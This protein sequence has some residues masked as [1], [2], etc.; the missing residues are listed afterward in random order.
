MSTHRQF[1]A[2]ISYRHVDPDRTW[3]QWLHRA[4]ESYRVPQGLVDKGY[5]KR[6]GVVFRDEDELA[7]SHDLSE[8]I[9]AALEASAHLLV[10]CSPRTPSSEWVNAEIARFKEMGRE[11]DVL[12][13]LIDGEPTESFPPALIP[14]LDDSDRTLP[15]S[16]E[17]EPLAAD[18]RPID[19]ESLRSRRRTALLRI[20]AS[21]LGCRYDDLRRREAQRRAKRRRIVAAAGL[22]LIGVLTGL[23][24]W[25]LREQARAEQSAQH[26][27]AQRERAEYLLG[28]TTTFVPEILRGIRQ[29][30]ARLRGSTRAQRRLSETIASYLDALALREGDDANLRTVSADTYQRLASIQ[31]G[32]EGNTLGN[33]Q[34]AIAQFRKAL[35]LYDQLAAELPEDRRRMVAAASARL[36]LAAV[37]RGVGDVVKARELIDVARASLER[38]HEEAPDDHDICVG[39]Y[40]ARRDAGA[41]A[42]YVGDYTTALKHFEDA[43]ELLKQDAAHIG[44][45]THGLELMLVAEANFGRALQLVGRADEAKPHFEET[46]RLSRL[47]EQR[48]DVDRLTLWRAH[49]QLGHSDLDAGEFPSAFLHFKRAL[50][51]AQAAVADDP[52][53]AAAG[54]SALSAHSSL[55]TTLEKLQRFKEA[56]PHVQ[57]ALDAARI[58]VKLDEQDLT[59]QW[60]LRVALTRVGSIQTRLHEFD[61]ARKNL[62]AARAIAKARVKAMPT[63]EERGG[64][65]EVYA[66]F[67]NLTMESLSNEVSL[68]E[69]IRVY[70][71]V[72]GWYERAASIYRAMD[73][74]GVLAQR[75]RPNLALHNTLV[76]TM[77][78]AIG[79]LEKLR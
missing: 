43:L 70:G 10:V 13:L 63:P 20:A 46:A 51:L 38:L 71:E 32:D 30:V 29:E 40:S 3:A 4:L 7:A 49:Y 42:L 58:A 75:W 33:H 11:D 65:A 69:N 52:L 35:G 66:S 68:E 55:G 28:R 61:E 73:Q 26:A 37:Y 18:V 8:E 36:G 15:R 45:T 23:V 53:D 9:E 12:A 76:A 5:P 31:G 50:E 41:T 60:D 1:A 6:I 47:V 62:E 67:G 2:F 74:E 59:A 39:T 17:L 72:K 16:H 27:I 79:K 24:V 25:A 77:E 78:E 54:V 19:D 22:V 14:E 44:E 64:L 21:I 34:E 56:L 57:K 48:P